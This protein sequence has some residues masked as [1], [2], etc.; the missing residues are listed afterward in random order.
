MRNRVLQCA[1]VLLLTGVAA[2]AQVVRP[3]NI[4]LI[5]ADDAGYHDF[6]FQNGDPAYRKATPHID[7]IARDGVR[8]SQAYVSANVCA[9]SRA[10]MLTGM[11]QQRAGFR[12]NFPAHWGKTPDKRWLND[13]WKGMG[14]DPGVKTVADHLRALGYRTG[15]VGKWHLGYADRF[16]PNQRGFDYF[17]G[18]RGGSR[19]FFP[20]EKFNQDLVPEKYQQLEK[21]G[22]FLPESAIRHVTETQGDAAIEFLDEAQSAGKPFFLFLSF[23]APHEPLQPDAQSLAAAQELF[24]DAGKRRQAYMGLVIGMD[25]QVGRVLGHLEACGLE[26]NT[27]VVF[28]SD[29]G[30]SG[31]NASD[32]APL[33]GYKWSPFEGGYRVP[34]AINWPG[35]AQPGTTVS[36]PVISLD[37]LPTFVAAAGGKLPGGLDGKAL[38]PLLAGGTLGPRTF[39]WWDANGEGVTATL[40]Q[41]PWKLVVRQAGGKAA[42]QDRGPWLFNLGEDLAE[43]TNLAGRHPETVQRL[44]ATIDEWISRMPTPR[45]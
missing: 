11:H 28:L 20:V 23:T 35:V 45:W 19:S 24:P 36:E 3:P 33:R 27:V 17:N 8:F 14:L 30:G 25:R 16:A 38:Q 1:A 12:D 18:L 6:G 31:K 34:L 26:K 42:P 13:A 39:C 41:H 29:N 22:V 9:P 21:N 7:G 10:G 44:K 2:T 32:N 40:V 15:I 5:L 43:T 4:L 37:L